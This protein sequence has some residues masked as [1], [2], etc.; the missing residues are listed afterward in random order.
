MYCIYLNDLACQ[1]KALSFDWNS[2]IG[3]VDFQ[4]LKNASIFSSNLLFDI[5]K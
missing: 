2:K 1:N 5:K 4:P 3:S